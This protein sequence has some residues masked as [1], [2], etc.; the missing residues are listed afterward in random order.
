ME[1]RVYDLHSLDREVTCPAGERIGERREGPSCRCRIEDALI[2]AAHDV[3]SLST[4][5]MGEHTMCPTWRAV[6]EL[7]WQNQEF[8]VLVE[9]SG[10]DRNYT[11]ADLQEIEER[12]AAGD[13]EGA[14][15][16][17]DRILDS[18]ASQGLVDPAQ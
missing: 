3:S 6:R 1:Q 5:C 17:A 2:T 10:L 18:R 12:Q 9:R 13:M 16:I 8:E 11:V 4:F 7:E 14:Q 15:K